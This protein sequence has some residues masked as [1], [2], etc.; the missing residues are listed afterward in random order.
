MVKANEEKSMESMEPPSRRGHPRVRR[1]VSRRG[2]WWMSA[3]AAS[4]SSSV[5]KRR[6]KKKREDPADTL[7][8]VWVP[9]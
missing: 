4:S 6:K 1:G 8:L 9:V 2:D 3:R 5:G 7:A